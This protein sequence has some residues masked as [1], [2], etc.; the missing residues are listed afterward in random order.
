[1][2]GLGE[3]EALL[4]RDRDIQSA[5]N[6]LSCRRLTKTFGALVALNRLSF[7]VEKGIVF[8]IGGPNGAG[9]TTL[10]DLICGINPAS[11]GDIIF[12]G[13]SIVGKRPFEICRAGVARTFQLNAAFETMTVRE[14]VLIASQHGLRHVELPQLTY[15]RTQRTQADNIIEA[16]GLKDKAEQSVS[17]L[18]MFD[19]KLMMIASALATRPRLLLLDEPVAGLIPAEIDKVERVIRTV[20]EDHSLTVILIEHVMRFLV[21][22]SDEVMIINHGEKLYQG[23]PE[24]L[25]KDRQVVDVYLGEGTSARLGIPPKNGRG[26]EKPAVRY[27]EAPALDPEDSQSGRLAPGSTLQPNPS[28][29]AVELSDNGLS[30]S[31]V[32]VSLQIAAADRQQGIAARKDISQAPAGKRIDPV[33]FEVLRNMFEYACERMTTVMQRTSFSPILADMLDF[34]NAVYDPDLRLLAQAANCPVHL[35]AMQYSADSAVQRFPMTSLLTGDVIALNDPFRGGTHIND[36]TFTMPIFF[37]GAL[38]GF[39]VSRGHWM[40]L[41]GGAA[42]GQSFGTHIAAEGLR[43]PPIKLYENY[44]INEDYLAIIMNNTRTPHFVKGD[45]QAHLGALKAAEGELQRAASRYGIETVKAAM[46]EL[47]A[48]TE[49]VVRKAI[50]DIPDGIYQAEDYADTDGFSEEPIKVK[51]T[52][53]V[54]G[55]EIVVDFAGSDPV[56]KG[57]INS[58]FANTASAA[59]YS[60]QFFLAPHAPSNSG[61]FAPITISV[62]DDCWLNARWP[63]PTIGCT[64]IVSSKICS[65]I[66]QALAEAIPQRVTGSTCSEANW[67]VAATRD[68]QGAT[69]VFSELPAGGWGGT[70]FNDGMSVTMDPLGNCMNMPAE[71]AE[72]LFPIEYEAFELRCDSAGP[73]KNRGGLGAVF[74]VRFRCDGELSMETARTREGSPGVNGGGRSAVQRASQIFADGRELVIGGLSQNGAWKNPLL[75]GH[76]FGFDEQF[77]FETTGGGGWGPPKERSVEKVFED[78]LDGYVSV[79]AARDMYGVVVDLRGNKIDEAA[80]ARLRRR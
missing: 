14:N 39:A 69:D 20:I 31:N 25:S 28:G 64:T 44:K 74:K 1:M 38:L 72:L 26:G 29:L 34:S 4:E 48:Y 59:Y 6:I 49:R 22:L 11:S 51:V 76:R 73:G 33:T 21:G 60:L 78:V 40:D 80:T 8:G 13:K 17:R 54:K 47:I 70:P 9:K 42:G 71:T 77:K 46:T 63:A 75:A 32:G 65:A 16:C 66:W 79:E 58:P 10:F 68:P 5:S 43:L 18:S 23:S 2:R 55:S 7:D 62:P 24:G 36:I 57:A 30:S 35:A 61:M 27:A 53:T 12:D 67:F 3:F 15:D 56:C 37:E 41:G 45:L 52:L 50:E 19:H